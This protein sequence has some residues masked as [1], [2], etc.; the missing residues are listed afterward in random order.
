MSDGAVVRSELSA[1]D[2]VL[3]IHGKELDQSQMEFDL[4]SERFDAIWNDL[5][6]E[7]VE[8][9]KDEDGKLQRLPGEDVRNALIT[10]R[11]REEHPTI[12]DQYHRLKNDLSRLEKKGKRIER[13]MYS[14]QTSLSWLKTEAQAIG[15]G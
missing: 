2:A 7:F 8:P 9:Y 5:V 3:D 6:V 1:L 10:K 14:K 12:F 13:L 15:A 11:M 4:I